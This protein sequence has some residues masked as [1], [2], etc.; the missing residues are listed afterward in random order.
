[1][2]FFG[3]LMSSPETNISRFVFARI[4][5]RGQS[6][7]WSVEEFVQDWVKRLHGDELRQ[8][9]RDHMVEAMNVTR[10]L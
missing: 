2:K 7:V 10:D 9:V 4:K 8:V 3:I 1:M 5:V 6:L